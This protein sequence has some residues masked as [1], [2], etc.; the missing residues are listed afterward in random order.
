MA[1]VAKVG[2]GQ[3]THLVKCLLYKHKDI[4]SVP[5]NLR[6][7]ACAQILVWPRWI[8]YIPGTYRLTSLDELLNFRFNERPCLKEKG[9][10]WPR[11]TFDVH[12]YPLACMC[13]HTH[14]H[15]HMCTTHTHTHKHVAKIP[16]RV[17]TIQMM[18]EKMVAKQE[19]YG[20]IIYDPYTETLVLHSF[21]QEPNHQQA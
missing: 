18:V 8:R 4:S 1:K 14:K 10:E 21:Y 13:A 5:Q 17:V 6:C 11:K 12:I 15:V 16:S 9:G 7:M 3:M 2:A 19:Y 20:K